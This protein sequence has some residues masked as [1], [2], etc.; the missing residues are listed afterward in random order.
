LI[1]NA[2]RLNSLEMHL[3]GTKAGRM[4]IGELVPSAMSHLIHYHLRDAE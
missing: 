2:T 4:T 1:R 3:K